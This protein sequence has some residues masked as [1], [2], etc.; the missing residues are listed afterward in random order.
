MHQDVVLSANDDGNWQN[1]MDHV[2][3]VSVIV[4]IGLEIALGVAGARPENAGSGSCRNL[5][6]E[7]P[8]P[9]NTRLGWIEE[10]RCV[11]GLSV[12]V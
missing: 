9:P 6:L 5:P 11:P 10:L 3:A 7:L 4:L 2:A 1:V 12:V 8:S